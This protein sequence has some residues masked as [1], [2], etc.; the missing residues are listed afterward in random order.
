M[1]LNV[2]AITNYV[3]SDEG[4]Q[5]HLSAN[6]DAIGGWEQFVISVVGTV[7]PDPI[8]VT[9]PIPTGGRVLSSTGHFNWGDNDHRVDFKSQGGRGGGTKTTTAVKG[10]YE[11]VTL[12][13]DGG[14]GQ[15]PSFFDE[16]RMKG[17]DFRGYAS[18]DADKRVEFW[19]RKNNG[20]GTVTIPNLQF[21]SILVVK[22]NGIEFNLDGM[23]L[24]RQNP[25][26]DCSFST[27]YNVPSLES[28][29]G[30][31]ILSYYHDDPGEL[32]AIGDGTLTFNEWDGGDGTST[33][34]YTPGTVPPKRVQYNN[35]GTGGRQL[36][37]V[38]ANIPQFPA[39]VSHHSSYVSQSVSSFFHDNAFSYSLP[40]AAFSTIRLFDIRGRLVRTLVNSLQQPGSYS[41][42]L[43]I[44]LSAGSY[45][46]SF[47]AGEQK[48]DKL[49]PI[50]IGQ[51]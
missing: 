38:V 28:Y 1:R 36:V 25:D 45:L 22:G 40:S 24:N 41:A 31:T 5:K 3:F 48:V 34:L 26:C 32:T 37:G 50:G 44:G 30:F 18:G 7:G 39:S 9:V 27:F 46:V 42:S 4:L 23:K 16:N 6:R 2:Q 49:V 33:V 12:G 8:P 10:D 43:P 11:I 13:T 20:Q 35:Y 17:Q 15:H 29:P 14:P 21:W 51:R 19:I 47:R